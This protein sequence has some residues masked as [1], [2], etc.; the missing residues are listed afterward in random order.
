MSQIE[1]LAAMEHAPTLTAAARTT[2]LTQPAASRLLNALEEDLGIRLFERDGRSVAPTDAGRKLVRK[3]A[4]I[5]AELDR[6]QKEIEAIDT[7]LEGLVSVGTSVSSSY[8][9]L[10]AAISAM[11]RQWPGLSV[12]VHEGSMDELLRHLREG[13]IDLLVGRFEEAVALDDIQVRP[14]HNPTAKVVCGPQHAILQENDPTWERVLDEQWI[15]PERGTP[16]WAAVEALFKD[17]GRRPGSWIE[18]SDIPAN[19]HLLGEFDLIWVLSE[20]VARYFEGLGAL[21]ML[22]HLQLSSPGPFSL[23]CLRGREL[24]LAA[25]CLRDCLLGCVDE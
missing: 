14:L 5:I 2:H 1:L 21:S 4:Q 20:D 7:G 24:S 17:I 10:P 23:G 13:R 12:S 25:E 15:M 22:G 19:V 11:H 3:S 18:S 6:M 8:V 16:M 9:L